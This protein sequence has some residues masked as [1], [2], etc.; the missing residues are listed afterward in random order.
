MVWKRLSA[1]WVSDDWRSAIADGKTSTRA[2]CI[3]LLAWTSQF[4]REDRARPL[5]A[6]ERK[7]ERW[8]SLNESASSVV[9]LCEPPT[10]YRRH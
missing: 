10:A 5:A 6:N 7:Q 3:P 1:W 8:E 9:G 4:E 2:A